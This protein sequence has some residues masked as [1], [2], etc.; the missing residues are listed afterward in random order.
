MMDLVYLSRNR[1]LR[2]KQ[3]YCTSRELALQ[4]P[5]MDLHAPT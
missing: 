5:C 1:S 3:A 4:I 2:D